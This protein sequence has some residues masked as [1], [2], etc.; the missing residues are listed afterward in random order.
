MK[1]AKLSPNFSPCSSNGVE[2]GEPNC[3]FPESTVASIN[4]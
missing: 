1:A 4:V 2:F 3:G